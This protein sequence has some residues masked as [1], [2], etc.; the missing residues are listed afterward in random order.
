MNQVNGVSV[1][2][3][4]YGNWSNNLEPAIVTDYRR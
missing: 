4:W 1:Y 3:I 2:L